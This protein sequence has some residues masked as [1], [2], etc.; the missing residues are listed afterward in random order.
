M[1]P[2]YPRGVTIS[3]LVLALALMGWYA[4]S[5]QAAGDLAAARPVASA[6]ALAAT[7]FLL[8]R[9][10]S[11]MHPD[12]V[13]V[14]VVVTVSLVA[15]SAP[16]IVRG[17]PTAGPLGY[18]NANAALVT[19]GVAAACLL[20]VRRGNRLW[21]AALALG[22]TAV[23]LA[24]RSLAGAGLSIAVLAM[25]AAVLHEG[26][27]HRHVRRPTGSTARQRYAL[28]GVVLFL[29]GLG[30][31][32]A[33][34]AAY[35]PH[36]PTPPQAVTRS[37]EL[38]SERRLALWRDAEHLLGQH[39]ATGVGPG[40]FAT[41]SPTAIADPDAAWAHSQPL[42]AAAETGWVGGALTVAL[43][44]WGFAALAAGSGSPGRT[45]VGVAAWA[46]LALHASEDYVLHFP[47]VLLAGVAVLAAATGPST[48]D[49]EA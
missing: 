39:P 1:R 48:A 7:A 41:T 4:Y 49:E 29:V 34:A 12:L 42:Q 8:A 22:L 17:S 20:A 43:L 33:V 32:V 18:G 40:S 36:D 38:V 19:Q 10:G 21:A 27:G 24:T 3:G 14:A 9:Q 26:G 30:A 35:D 44:L 46:A 11:V 37:A 25:T 31:S 15:L 47:V 6:L 23:A 5:A 45:A 16:E 13:P 2:R 28:A